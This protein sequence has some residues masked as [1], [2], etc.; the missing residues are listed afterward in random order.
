MPNRFSAGS[1]EAPQSIRKL[2][3][4]PVTWKQ[5][6]DRPP[7]P[8]ASPQPTKRN[9]IGYDPV[10]RE[11]LSSARGAEQPRQEPD[12]QHDHGAEQEVAPQPVDGVEAQIPDSLEQEANAVDNIPRVESDRGKH[13]T[14]QDREQDQPERHRKRRAAEKA[15]QAVMVGGRQVSD[16]VGHRSSPHGFA[17]PIVLRQGAHGEPVSRHQMLPKLYLW[18]PPSASARASPAGRPRAAACPSATG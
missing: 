18:P 12:R 2:T 11:K 5:A 1:D 7:A 15:V 10:F 6:L 17:Q 3:S 4:R 13:D 9:C 16:V 8:N 14:D